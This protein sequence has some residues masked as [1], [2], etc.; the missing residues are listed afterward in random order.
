MWNTGI[1][2]Y[3]LPLG[4]HHD[5]LSGAQ[6]MGSHMLPHGVGTL[7]YEQAT[8]HPAGQSEVQVH[9][10]MVVESLVVL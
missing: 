2:P 4:I 8:C 1:Y 3:S 5:G 10:G 7:S 6:S 9:P